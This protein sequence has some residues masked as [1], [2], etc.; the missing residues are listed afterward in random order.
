LFGRTV[1]PPYAGRPTV[2]GAGAELIVE[3]T[4]QH[5]DELLRDL[6]EVIRKGDYRFRDEPRTDGEHTAPNR[7]IA[8]A[9]GAEGLVDLEAGFTR[10]SE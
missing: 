4:R 7:A 6:D 5:I 2:G 1:L 3:G 9:A 10:S 8:W